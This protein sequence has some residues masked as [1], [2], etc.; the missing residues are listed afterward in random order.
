MTKIERKD[1]WHYEFDDD[2]DTIDAL[3]FVKTLQMD[4]KN[5]FVALV[6]THQFMVFNLEKPELHGS[7]F[8]YPK[9]KEKDKIYDVYIESYSP[10]TF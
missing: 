4:V 1:G 10:T 9:K 6:G 2:D 5:K 8:C 7:Q 3:G